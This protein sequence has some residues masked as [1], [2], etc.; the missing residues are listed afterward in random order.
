MS[1]INLFLVA[2]SPYNLIAGTVNI[3]PQPTVTTPIPFSKVT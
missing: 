2:G 3:Q 1:L